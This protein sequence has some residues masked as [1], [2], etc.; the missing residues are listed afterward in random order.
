[1]S[2]LPNVETS[3]FTVMSKMAVEYNA[4]N[5][6]QGFPNFPVDER[7]TQIVSRI[8]AEDVH[9][10]TPMAGYP[11]LLNKIASLL[12]SSYQRKVFPETEILVTAGATQAI[13][14][15]L[16]ALLKPNDE[17]IILDPSYD[18]YEAP[19]LLSNA[20][21]VRVALND[22]YTVN[23]NT[24]ANAFSDK[25]KMIIINNPHNP[26][27]KILNESDLENLEILLE[28]HPNVLL[29]SDEV[30]EHITFEQKHIS[31]HT[32]EK[33]LNRCI[34]I[35][36]FGKSFHVTGWKIGYLIAPEYLM[37][38][39]KKVH[40]FLVFSVNSICQVAVSEYLDLVKLEEISPFYQQKRDYFRTLLKNSR[41]QL[42]PCEGTYFQ[43][44]SYANISNENDVDFC[45][46]LI[47][48]YGVAAIPISN[49]YADGKDLK[50]IRFCF[51]KDNFTLEEAARRLEK[52]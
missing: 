52:I 33:L 22:D 9:Q 31:T 26:T 40:Q 29:L 38:E 37:K 49:F 45:K 5:L 21:P 28:K 24:I 36:S 6:S 13:F 14:T 2:K 50:L 43:V 10:Y 12:K 18:C 47:T 39:I 42:M 27:G 44:A 32:R 20:K 25:T 15:T 34:M 3:I 4:I 23:W 41:F 16:L 51:A 30:Y 46:R 35:S 11:P 1:M 17:V 19:I 7:L 8:S 48:D